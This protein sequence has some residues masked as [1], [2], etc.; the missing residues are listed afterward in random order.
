MKITH[1]EKWQVVVPLRE[2]VLEK[3][4][5]YAYPQF[6]ATPKWIIRIHADNGLDGVGESWR[7]ENEATI[8]S[9][10]AV[11]VGSDPRR[12][13]LHALPFPPDASYSTVEMA[14][15]DLLGKHWNVPAYQLLGGALQERV[16]VSSWAARHSPQET[17]RLAAT[18]KQ[19]GFRNFKLKA[20]LA[21]A[22]PSESEQK[23][24]EDD[25]VLE[26]VQ[27]I[28]SACGSGFSVTIDANCRFYQP[29]NTIKLARAL[30]GKD[31]VLEDPFSWQDDL[32]AYV[33][34]RRE[35]PVP[36]AIHIPS[37]E[38]MAANTAL[39][40]P[41]YAVH[42]G[43]LGMLLQVIKLKAADVVNLGGPMVEFV[44]LAWLANEAG[45]DC[46]HESGID[47]GIR[48]ASS[49]HASFAA[50]N[51]LPGDMQGHFLRVDDLIEQPLPIANGY[52]DRPQAPG[53]GVTLDEEALFRYVV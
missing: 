12:L 7:G 48:D 24:G 14:L 18:A 27:A 26:T 44:R 1:F 34:L 50:R 41:N 29:E 43:S 25:P 15:F 19:Q 46:W 45:I 36:I 3:V 9:A 42:S 49:M 16:A 22:V 5:R 23:A 6:D 2:G 35:S 40:A 31:V 47:L 28:A 21:D 39:G 4:G 33:R 51:T 37:S 32:G 11:L 8:D 13:P 10:I 20:W 38:A 53:L 52:I 30:A 17:A